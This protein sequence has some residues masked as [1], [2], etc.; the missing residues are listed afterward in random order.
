MRT[1]TPTTDGRGNASE[2]GTDIASIV[3]LALRMPRALRAIGGVA[4]IV[5]ATLVGLAGPL[6]WLDAWR[7]DV[8]AA[9][10]VV[11]IALLVGSGMLLVGLIAIQA[12]FRP[13]ARRLGWAALAVIAL[14]VMTVG[15]YVGFVLIPLGL[16]TFGIAAYSDG[17]LP[18]GAQLSSP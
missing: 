5:G 8:G 4:A 13:Q 9:K 7:M 6:A 11:D 18:R 17:S 15:A 3:R 1:R 16:T 10:D 12:T 2:S 14:G